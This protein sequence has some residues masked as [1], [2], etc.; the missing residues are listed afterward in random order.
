MALVYR[1][2]VCQIK[3]HKIYMKNN[4]WPAAEH[5]L[6]CAYEYVWWRPS[7]GDDGRDNYYPAP[8]DN[9]KDESGFIQ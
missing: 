8:G 4:R 6:S 9:L 5:N 1:K 7:V 3:R 2:V